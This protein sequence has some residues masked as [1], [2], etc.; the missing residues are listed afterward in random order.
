MRDDSRQWP[1]EGVEAARQGI[2]KRRD[3]AGQQE[4]E[5]GQP[6]SDALRQM[7]EKVANQRLQA[8]DQLPPDPAGQIKELRDYDFMDQDAR[9]KFDELM[10]ILEQQIL[11][12]QFE[13]LK[14]SL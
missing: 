1:E 3:Q 7:L 13:G 9:Q 2:Q 14:Q 6:P 11:G 12:N 8:L 4:Q 5:G 10:K